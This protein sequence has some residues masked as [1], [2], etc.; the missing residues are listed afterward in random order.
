M[1]KIVGFSADILYLILDYFRFSPI[2]LRRYQTRCRQIWRRHDFA[3]AP[4]A[5]IGSETER[6]PLALG[7][8]VRFRPLAKFAG[9][10]TG[11]AST[12][13]IDLF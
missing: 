9:P 7:E 11:P 4:S 13:Q 10:E 12:S 6:G 1:D 5:V 8:K 3:C 2:S